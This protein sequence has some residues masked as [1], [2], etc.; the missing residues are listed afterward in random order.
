MSPRHSSWRRGQSRHRHIDVACVASMV[1]L[2]RACAPPSEASARPGSSSTRPVSPDRRGPSP[3]RA[4]RDLIECE[5]SLSRCRTEQAE[6]SVQAATVSC[7]TSGATVWLRRSG[8]LG[9]MT[10]QDSRL[11]HSRRR[12][13]VWVLFAASDAAIFRPLS[14]S[15]DT[16]LSG[17]LA[18][19]TELALLEGAR[20]VIFVLEE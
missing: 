16:T 6:S 2:M 9:E 13:V 17:F 3:A 12:T 10:A 5:P 4:E 7:R 18:S 8:S 20:P 1:S 19:A 14:A 15:M 11:F